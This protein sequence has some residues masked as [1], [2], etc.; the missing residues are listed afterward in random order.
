MGVLTYTLYKEYCDL[1]TEI[2]GSIAVN[3]CQI[4]TKRYNFYYQIICKTGKCTGVESNKFIH[5]NPIP[6][7]RQIPP[8]PPPPPPLWSF[9]D[10][11]ICETFFLPKLPCKLVLRMSLYF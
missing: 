4:S 3:R 7:D 11:S 2:H 1:Y 8:P 6:H 9:K 10:I 5:F